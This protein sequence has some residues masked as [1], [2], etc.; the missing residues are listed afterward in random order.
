MAITDKEEGVWELDQVYNKINQGSIWE[1][2]G[3][4]AGFVWGRNDEGGLGINLSPNSESRSSPVQLPGSWKEMSVIGDSNFGTK[5]DG[6]LWAWGSNQNG[7]LGQNT[8]QHFSSPVQIGTET[9]WRR[10]SSYP[11]GGIA[12]K[13]DGSLWMWGKNDS[14]CLGQN[15]GEPSVGKYSSPIQIPGTWS[16]H[17]TTMFGGGS[18]AINTDGELF[19]WGGNASGTL[20][21]NNRTQYSSPVQVP[22]TTWSRITQAAESGFVVTK[23]D[24]TAW[25]WGS[26]DNGSLGLNSTIKYSSP[27]QIPGTTWQYNFNSGAFVAIGK[28]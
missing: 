11:S 13:T 23:T 25:A 10:I 14:G 12:T 7:E 9:T 22:G 8:T 16:S 17:A 18:A 15:Q 4:G 20:G 19:M 28:P 6:T 2:T 5:T 26:N 27:V 21:Q 3:D 1:Y 24:G